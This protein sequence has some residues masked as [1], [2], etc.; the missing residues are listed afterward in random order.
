MDQKTESDNHKIRK[1]LRA[2]R[3]K[4][5]IMT[6]RD[7]LNTAIRKIANLAEFMDDKWIEFVANYLKANADDVYDAYQC[8]LG[9]EEDSE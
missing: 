9:E 4:N 1:Q 2:I 7:S 8:H 5:P 3:K 6:T